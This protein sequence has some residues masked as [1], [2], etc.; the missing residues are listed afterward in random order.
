[1]FV[2]EAFDSVCKM[3]N[4][5]PNFSQPWG[6]NESAKAEYQGKQVPGTIPNI[7]LASLR[8]TESDCT[9]RPRNEQKGLFRNNGYLQRPAVPPKSSTSFDSQMP[10]RVGHHQAA[11]LA[12]TPKFQ[13]LER[14]SRLLTREDTK[15][16]FQ[17]LDRP[18]SHC[19]SPTGLL[20]PM[21]ISYS[22][23]KKIHGVSE[24]TN[25]SVQ[26]NGISHRQMS[27]KK[28]IL[29]TKKP[30]TYSDSHLMSNDPKHRES[31][32]ENNQQRQNTLPNFV[33]KPI[34]TL[35]GHLNSLFPNVSDTG[36]SSFDRIQMPRPTT[37]DDV[38]SNSSSSDHTLVGNHSLTTEDTL[39]EE[40]LGVLIDSGEDSSSSPETVSTIRTSSRGPSSEEKLFHVAPQ[41]QKEQDLYQ[42]KYKT[43][44]IFFDLYF[45]QYLM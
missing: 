37:P 14:N 12:S 42:K 26:I 24:D 40:R 22:E 10:P 16:L 31:L 9:L 33:R 18:T 43:P 5:K 20:K 2:V 34:A 7:P 45:I 15:F 38:S 30:V 35:P 3:F 21:P 29:D 17:P 25:A 44:G 19:Q 28:Y 36:V 27:A 4:K 11:S 41:S 39:T 6:I 1:M 13:P 32:E 23:W 8:I